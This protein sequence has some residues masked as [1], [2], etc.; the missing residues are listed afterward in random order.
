MDANRISEQLRL[1]FRES[2]LT[3][4]EVASR[5]EFGVSDVAVA[6]SR[7]KRPSVDLVEAVGNALGL[8]L[9]FVQAAIQHV[10]SEPRTV[11]DEAIAQVAPER[12]VY[13]REDWIKV[14]ALDLEA[15]LIS[16]AVSAF[17]RPGL[18]DFLE[19]VHGLF[20]RVVLFTTVPESKVRELALVF[21]QEKSVPPW[22]VAIEYVRWTGFTKDL[23]FIPHV[24]ADQVLLVD[25][26][27]QMV[28]PGQEGQWV[29]VRGYE[30]PF[31]RYDDELCGVLEVLVDRVVGRKPRDTDLV[32]SEC[33]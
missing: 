22:F 27:A 21:L 12:L 19:A 11:V 15:T 28:H 30:P 14:L 31:D 6:L 32:L 20:D 23:N 13:P 3:I 9:A 8:E 7:T 4:W 17:T 16:T 10:V 25:D 1:A 29:R 33:R 26:M 18:Y 24:T 5:A 2:G